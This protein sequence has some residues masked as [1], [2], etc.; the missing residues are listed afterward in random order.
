[1]TE[2]ARSMS[3]LLLLN[4]SFQQSRTSARGREYTLIESAQ[5]AHR[6]RKLVPLVF[7]SNCL[8]FL[9]QD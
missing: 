3:A 1:M 4:G 7:S 8:A 9:Y 2:D 6:R 5:P